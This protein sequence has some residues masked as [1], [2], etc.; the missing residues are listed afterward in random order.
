[1]PELPEVETIRRQLG[2]VVEGRELTELE[3]LDS[4]WCL[5]LAP[6]AVREALEG[7]ASSAS[8]GAASTSC[9]SSKATR[10]CSCTCA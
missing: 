8:A 7:G 5:P 3:I 6:E 10:S 4:R 9:G 2:P 1:M